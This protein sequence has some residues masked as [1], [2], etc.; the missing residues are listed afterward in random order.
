MPRF[1]AQ[2]GFWA[3]PMLLTGVLMLFE[4]GRTAAG[5]RKRAP[6]GADPAGHSI[7]VW[8]ALSAVLGILG[9]VVGI[10]IAAGVIENASS[11]SP[12]LVAGGLKVALSTTVFGMLLFALALVVWRVI[13]FVE[14]RQARPTA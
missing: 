4:I 6:R 3:Y 1:F 10:S 11:I 13:R 5:M 2:M 7:L 14:G 9:T 8:G 12:P